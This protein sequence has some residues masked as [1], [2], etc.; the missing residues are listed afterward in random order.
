MEEDQHTIAPEGMSREETELDPELP[1][2]TILLIVG[3]VCVII[4]SIIVSNILKQRQD[5]AV[6]C[7]YRGGT[8][9]RDDMECI[10]EGGVGLGTE[11]VGMTVEVLTLTL[12]EGLAQPV[13][14]SF[15]SVEI[16]GTAAPAQSFALPESDARGS[17]S[18]LNALGKVHA[19]TKDLVVPFVVNT[20]G[21]G[22]FM[23]VGVFEKTEEGYVM[24]DAM[25]AGD[26]VSPQSVAIQGGAEGSYV[27]RFAYRD[28]YHDESMAAIP[29][30]PRTLEMYILNH[31]IDS[32]FVAGRDGVLYGDVLSLASPLPHTSVSSPLVV[33]GE[34]R[35]PWFFEASFPV[36]LAD[37]DGKI[38][39]QGIAR[40][41][42]EW[43]TEEF[44]P[45]E[46]TLTYTLPVDIPYR[47]GT[48]ILKKDNPSGL[49]EHDDAFEIP[50][51]FRE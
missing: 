42:G 3:L 41:Q 21:S 34:A 49:P 24:R 1:I 13:A 6:E 17:V 9:L 23:Y 19:A 44:V 2:K 28:R 5:P 43:M 15:S 31:V 33:S 51:T 40:A 26:R 50:V 47:R 30:E 48:L 38:I 20:G 8:W 46:A 29:T 12:S 36:V 11:Q 37:W 25:L 18:V 10:F 39:A 16:G 14:L 32:H 22:Q 35:G 45:F 7:A 4:S 27:A